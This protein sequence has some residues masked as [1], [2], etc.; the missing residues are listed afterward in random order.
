MLP[1]PPPVPDGEARPRRAAKSRRGAAL[2]VVSALMSLLLVVGLAGQILLVHPDPATIPPP[3]PSTAS[4]PT[5]VDAEPTEAPPPP[6]P[7][8]GLEAP[9]QLPE[10]EWEAL[11]AGVQDDTWA[12]LQ[13]EELVGEEPPILTGCPAVQ[14][15]ASE[16]EYQELVRQQWGCLHT[17]W[18]PLFE[19]KGWSTVKPSVVFYPGTGATSECG[20]LEAPAFYCSAGSGTV[21]FGAGHMEMATMWDPSINEMVN[22]EYAHHLQSLAGITTAKFALD[23]TD[24]LERRAELQATCWS[25]TMTRNSEAVDFDQES[26]DSWQERLETVIIDGIHGSRESI[27]HWGTRGLYSE[28]LEDCNTWAVDAGMVT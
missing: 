22:H 25:A 21:H 27:I 20:Y 3:L 13:P 17:A 23:P 16:E 24:E 8:A 15:V 9:W 28:T 4:S 12:A 1:Q 7:E 14:T 11:P 18:L 2:V 26:W 5:P 19:R 6:A 10:R